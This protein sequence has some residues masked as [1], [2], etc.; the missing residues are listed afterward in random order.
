MES[1]KKTTTTEAKLIADL[2]E[3]V[4]Q[5]QSAISALEGELHVVRR[6]LYR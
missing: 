6:E 4:A 5:L 2:R 3:Q 1:T